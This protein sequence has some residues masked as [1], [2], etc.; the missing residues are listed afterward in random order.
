M[1]TSFEREV[2]LNDQRVVRLRCIR[3]SDAPLLRE[4]FARLSPAS[5]YA[6][7]HTLLKELPAGLVREL[8]EVDGIDHAALV[9]IE[10]RSGVERGLGVARFVRSRADRTRAEL[11]VTI[12]DEAQ[13]LGLASLLIEP[14]A[15]VARA[16]GIDTFEGFV[17]TENLRARR[18][19]RKLGAEWLR[20]EHGVATY[21]LP[22]GAASSPPAAAA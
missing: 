21:R 17:L 19:L 4:G 12:A 16:Q 15:A 6:R 3:S 13:G 5:R 7:F 10:V 20:T 1:D 22:L 9:A 14:L 8:T 18:L 11:A 2:T